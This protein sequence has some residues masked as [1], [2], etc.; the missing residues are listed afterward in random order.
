MCTLRGEQI[1][2]DRER[3]SAARPVPPARRWTPPHEEPQAAFATA[4]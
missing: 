4:P 2:L 1:L 3:Y